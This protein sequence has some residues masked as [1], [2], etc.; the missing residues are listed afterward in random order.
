MKMSEPT[1]EATVKNYADIFSYASGQPLDLPNTNE[2]FHGLQ[3]WV[4]RNNQLIY[5]LLISDTESIRAIQ[6]GTRIKL[7]QQLKE[8]N[9][10]LRLL[11][12]NRIT[13]K[14]T[15]KLEYAIDAL[16]QSDVDHDAQYIPMYT[17]LLM[18]LQTASKTIDIPTATQDSIIFD[19]IEEET[20]STLSPKERQHIRDT[21][22]EFA[23]RC[24]ST[25]TDSQKTGAPTT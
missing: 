20:E 6:P 15:N 18:S 13:D 4:E 8:R 21:A 7:I 22:K 9:K 3:A 16:M 14:L 12:L 1:Y 10:E 11:R 19:V 2:S 24:T 5:H 17:Q 25:S 23:K